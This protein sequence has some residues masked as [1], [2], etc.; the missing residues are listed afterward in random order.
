MPVPLLQAYLAFI[1]LK[2]FPF[3][4]ALFRAYLFAEV[5][6]V[7]AQPVRSVVHVPQWLYPARPEAVQREFGH[8]AGRA[9]VAVQV[10]TGREDQ[11]RG[12][13]SG[14]GL[15]QRAGYYVLTVGQVLKKSRVAIIPEF[16]FYLAK[17]R[18]RGARFGPAYLPVFKFV[19]C[20]YE[21]ALFPAHMPQSIPLA[22]GQKNN[23]YRRPGLKRFG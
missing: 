23:L 9:V 17:G 2:Q 19:F 4:F 14:Y 18:H 3:G 16:G 10:L 20:A 6:I 5:E 22:A 8:K 1:G 7:L 11:H 13:E 21:K 12:A 15:F